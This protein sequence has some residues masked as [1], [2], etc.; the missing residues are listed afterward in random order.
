MTPTP[1]IIGGWATT[2]TTNLPWKY[3]KDQNPKM[4]VFSG[5]FCKNIYYKPQF[6]KKSLRGVQVENFWNHDFEIICNLEAP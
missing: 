6:W 4:A 2:K 1:L 5:F 3:E